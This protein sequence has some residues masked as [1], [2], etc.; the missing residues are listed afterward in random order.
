M[1]WAYQKLAIALAPQ[2]VARGQNGE[3][4][5]RQFICGSLCTATI[6]AVS[7]GVNNARSL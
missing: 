3:R 5:T 1:N 2:A 4:G 6:A 7:L